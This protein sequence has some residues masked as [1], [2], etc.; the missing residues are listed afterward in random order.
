V[1]AIGLTLVAMADDRSEEAKVEA[2]ASAPAGRA[3][4]AG[5]AMDGTPSPPPVFTY[6]VQPG[7]NLYAIALRFGT[8]SAALVTRN[9][10]P[11]PNRISPG[12]VLAI[13]PPPAPPPPVP[14]T[15][16]AVIYHG[17]QTG[18]MV[19]LSFDAG[20]DVGYT[21]LI[22]DTLAANG[23]RASFGMTGR[24]AEQNPEMLQRIVREGHHLINHTYL[25]LDFR[26]IGTSERWAELDRTDAVLVALTG[27]GSRPFFRP[28]YG[29]YDASVNA[30]VAARGYT[31]NFMWTVDSLGWM[32]L[33]VPDIV[34]RCLNGAEPG[35]IYLF[36]V[37]IQ[38][39]DGPALQ[40]MIDGFRA[41]G[42]SMGSVADVMG[43]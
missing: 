21:A 1:L 35:A 29:G 43:F 38:S 37:G 24:W 8:T 40:K 4:L 26:T 16:A 41:M 11:N 17:D 33:S 34:S 42:Y 6:T 39:L 31:Y 27:I 32:G 9:G 19:A 5:V 25:H 20:S 30:D 23:L 13:G 22:L 14:P 18:R 15:S 2:A 7:D 10:L 3:F 28:P 36:H 12:T